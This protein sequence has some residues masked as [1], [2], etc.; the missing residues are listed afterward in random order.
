M[1]WMSYWALLGL[2]REYVKF[3]AFEKKVVESEEP[4]NKN[5]P[6]AKFASKYGTRSRRENLC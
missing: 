6:D 4:K 5:Y 2:W 3:D 1:T